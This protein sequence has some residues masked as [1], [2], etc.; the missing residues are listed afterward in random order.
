LRTAFSVYGVGGVRGVLA[1]GLVAAA[2]VA[3]SAHAAGAATPACKTPQCLLTQFKRCHAATY[4]LSKRGSVVTFSVA[5][6]DGHC[7][8][9]AQP[10]G[11]GAS[12]CAGLK[13]KGTDVVAVNCTGGT[14]PKTISLTGR[15]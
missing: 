13:A 12:F 14:L 10:K 5:N 2:I 4:T 9:S 3:S 11:G 7:F 15:S 8:V 6:A 1:C